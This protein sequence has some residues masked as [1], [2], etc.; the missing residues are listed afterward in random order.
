M[1]IVMS[2]R[3]LRKSIK[4]MIEKIKKKHDYQINFKGLIA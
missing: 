1:R 3:G 2:A 4:E